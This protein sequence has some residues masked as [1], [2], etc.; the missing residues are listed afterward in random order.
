VVGSNDKQTVEERVLSLGLRTA[1]G[2]V[3]VRNGL[4]V[5]EQLVVRGAAS[6]SDQVQV[7]V[8]RLS[9]PETISE[10]TVQDSQTPATFPPQP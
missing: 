8:Q 1:N 7:L 6:L 9:A 4:V 3:E 10:M 5:G 2:L